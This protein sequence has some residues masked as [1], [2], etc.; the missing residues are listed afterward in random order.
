MMDD[1]GS[2]EIK[3]ND[4]SKEVTIRDKGNNI[5]W[6]GPWDT[7]QDKAAAPEDVRTRVERLNFDTKF[8]G[9]GLR[10]Q[11]RPMPAPAPDEA[12]E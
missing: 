5:T 2:V 1:Q 10:L 11:M 7:E 4:G 3:S 6:T 8:K 12:P 9:N